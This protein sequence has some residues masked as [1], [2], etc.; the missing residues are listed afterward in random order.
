MVPNA[1][2]VLEHHLAND[3]LLAQEWQTSFKLQNDPRITRVGKLLRKTSLD[4]LPQ[5]WN[6]LVGE[7]SLVGRAPHHR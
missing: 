2:E 5:L 1:Q 7:M 3:P 6:V 4:E